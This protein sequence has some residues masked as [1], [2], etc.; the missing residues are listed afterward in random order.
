M[1][2]AKE[3]HDSDPEKSEKP[4]DTEARRR[5][6]AIWNEFLHQ[7]MSYPER[8]FTGYDFH[9]FENNNS[10]DDDLT[11]FIPAVAHDSNTMFNLNEG[12]IKI[13]EPSNPKNRKRFHRLIAWG[14]H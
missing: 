4:E 1:K 3:K 2:L 9:D 12:L 7:E 5:T 13:D 6:D 11:M 8:L 10:L 14:R